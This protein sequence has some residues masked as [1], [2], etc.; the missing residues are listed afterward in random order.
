M[1]GIAPHLIDLEI[2]ETSIME[3][4]QKIL[5]LFDRLNEYGVSIS[6]DDFGTGYSSLAYLKRLQNSRIKIDKSF[7]D[8]I[9]CDAGDRAIATTII[10]LGKN[11]NRIILAEGVETEK[12]LAVL[13]ELGCDQVQGYLFSKPVPVMD[14]PQLLQKAY[15][16]PI[17]PEHEA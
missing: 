3:Y 6:I 5:D 15:W 13:V 1:Q 2:T 17:S 8:H 14:V 12:Q 7:V 9:D 4:P 10:D 11:L 16:V